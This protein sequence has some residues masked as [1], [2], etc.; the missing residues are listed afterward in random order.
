MAEMARKLFDEMPQR[1]LV[2][3]T[4]MI[5]SYAEKENA[6]EALA[7]FNQMRKYGFVLDRITMVTVVNACAKLGSLNKAREVHCYIIENNFLINTILSTAM[8]D[9]YAKCGNV[10]AAREVFNSTKDKNV[11][12]WSTMIAAY[13]YHGQGRRALDLLPDLLRSGILPNKITFMS[14]LYA[15]SHSSL[16]E[17]GLRVF[18]LM[19][20]VYNVHPDV[21]HCTCVVDMLGRAGRFKQALK[22]MEEM[23]VE[24]DKGLWGAL[25]GACRIHKR[26]DLAERAAKALLEMK[27]DNPGHYAL[28]SNIY[29]NAGRWEEMAR[30]RDLMACRKLKKLP[31]WT[32]IEVEDKVHRFGA[33]DQSHHQA[34]EIYAALKNLMGI[35]ELAGYVPDTNY[36]LHDAEEGV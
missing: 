13:G 26:I 2:A 30:V 27:S 5:G 36:V 4:V 12:T 15:C 11:V 19:R 24:K 6:G 35:L 33:G 18:S 10:D 9:M 29:A 8:I 31:G 14:L 25:L 3:W 32:W 23:D 1:D 7:L 34:D 20:D 22:F 16:V 21:K 28:L 17:D